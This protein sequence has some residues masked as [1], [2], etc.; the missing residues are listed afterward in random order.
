MKRAYTK[1]LYERIYKQTRIKPDPLVFL[2]M[3]TRAQTVDTR[4]FLF[5]FSS[6]LDTRLAVTLLFVSNKYDHTVS[7]CYYGSLFL[8]YCESK[9]MRWSLLKAYTTCPLIQHT[10][11]HTLSTMCYICIPYSGKFSL[12][13]IFE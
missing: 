8:H 7:S 11:S 12:V 2:G 1:Q 5:Y 3:A 13:Q 4:P 6:G 9:V 10:R